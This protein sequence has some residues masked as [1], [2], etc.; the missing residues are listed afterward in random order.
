[1]T[2]LLVAKDR[3]WFTWSLDM[4]ERRSTRGRLVINDII[5]AKLSASFSSEALLDEALAIIGLDLD[6][7][8][9][10]SVFLAGHA[11]RKYRSAGGPRST[12][13]ADF[14]IGAYALVGGFAILTRDPH[15]YRTYFPE[16]ESIIPD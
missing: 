13:L 12:V 9:K 2:G 3:I 8:P 16:V 14:F 10:T 4:L 1:L 5:Y 7:L 6:R 11:F 15:R